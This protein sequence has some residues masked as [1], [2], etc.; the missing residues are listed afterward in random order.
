M[1]INKT[2]QITNLISKCS[3]LVREISHLDFNE[4]K[5]STTTSSL[6]TTS[7]KRKSISSTSN[8]DT[9]VKRMKN[10]EKEQST[11]KSAPNRL[12]N[13]NKLSDTVTSNF[14]CKKCLSGV[15]TRLR[16]DINKILDESVNNYET[17]ENVR[18][19]I[20]ALF[21]FDANDTEGL[22]KSLN[23]TED[24]KGLTSVI[25][26]QCECVDD[27]Q[28]NNTY[29]IE[30]EEATGMT[31][32][33]KN[34][35]I[36]QRR[37]YSSYSANTLLHLLTLYNGN[38]PVEFV[39]TCAFLGLPLAQSTTNN[40]S[41]LSNGI[42]T[43]VIQAGEESVEQAL[44]EEVKLTYNSEQ[45]EISFE[46]WMLLE[47][48]ERE[49][50]G[51]VVS[52]DMG[53]QKRSSGNTYNSNSG[54]AFMIG[55]KTRKVIGMTLKSKICSVCNAFRNSR[56]SE[57]RNHDCVRNYEN[58]SKAMEADSCLELVEFIFDTYN[59]SVFL[60]YIV[61]DDDTTMK[62]IVTHE[63]EGST[64]GR[65]RI[66]IPIPLWYA[67]PTHR[68]K[69]VAKV[70]YKLAAMTLEQ[71]MVRK[72]DAMRVKNI[73]LISSNKQ[74]ARHLRTCR[75]KGTHLLNISLIIMNFVIPRGAT[76]RWK[77]IMVYWKVQKEK[78]IIGI[79]RIQRI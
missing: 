57:I 75:N 50:V 47:P 45:R 6:S 19:A 34:G 24:I 30:L 68:T 5:H 15:L 53:W 7:P 76:E 8:K 49:D 13:F 51:I 61:S 25:Q 55:A 12:I 66:L 40:Y 54:H 78:D 39:S 37:K 17:T 38:G 9:P 27:K 73:I 20:N 18:D 4:T 70:I 22:M 14:G 72:L 77:L 74:G 11:I 42:Y 41:R 69:V 23:I 35:D 65:L 46:D 32:M 31:S 67:D 52:F 58:S 33:K 79:R 60:E 48:K 3:S 28:S 43:K 2:S 36:D 29:K 1:N 63:G 26:I 62:A 59:G 56:A 64:K 71:S 10:E 21:Q 44:L 16:K